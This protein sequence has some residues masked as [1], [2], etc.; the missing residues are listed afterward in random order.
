MATKRKYTVENPPR[1]Y[2]VAKAIG[3]S[4]STTREILYWRFGYMGN[5]PS[6]RVPLSMAINILSDGLDR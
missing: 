1:V 4:S 5:S 2:E 3:L 6:S